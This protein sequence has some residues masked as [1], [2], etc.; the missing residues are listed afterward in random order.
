[1]VCLDAGD[2]AQLDAT[3]AA[4]A[5][6]NAAIAQLTDLIHNLAAFYMLTAA[7]GLL[8]LMFLAAVTYANGR[9]RR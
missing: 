6:T 5:A 8:F 9:V 2:C 3:N 7:L 1:M 4:I